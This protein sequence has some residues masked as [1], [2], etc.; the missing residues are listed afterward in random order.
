MLL[1][2]VELD[3]C[4]GVKPSDLTPADLESVSV[5]IEAAKLSCQQRQA[6]ARAACEAL[7][8]EA[9]RVG[10][11]L[12]RLAKPMAVLGRDAEHVLQSS[13]AEVVAAWEQALLLLDEERLLNEEKEQRRKEEER[14]QNEQLRLKEEQ[15]RRLDTEK[16]RRRQEE[17]RRKTDLLRAAELAAL[18]EVVGRL[19]S[20][21]AVR[22]SPASLSA[23]PKSLNV[24]RKHLP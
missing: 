7:E 15:Q 4:A 18:R 13:G 14:R 19:A 5:D 11:E 1:T 24:L 20:K 22:P 9:G 12:G 10:V 17:E 6:A 23:P 3:K 21:T 2:E 8:A 16:E